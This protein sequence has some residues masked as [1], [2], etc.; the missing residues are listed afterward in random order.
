MREDRQTDILI[1]IL[2]TLPLGDVMTQRRA[3]YEWYHHHHHHH[4]Q[5]VLNNLLFL[6][7]L[8]CCIFFYHYRGIKMNIKET[9]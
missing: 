4:H 6:Y 9:E 5:F 8:I 3:N 7:N 2:R 1:T